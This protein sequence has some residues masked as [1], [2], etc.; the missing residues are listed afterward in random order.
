MRLKS[1]WSGGR[2][3][4]PSETIGGVWL[5]KLGRGIWCGINGERFFRKIEAWN[6]EK[7]EKN[8]SSSC[9]GVEELMKQCKPC[10]NPRG[11]SECGQYGFGMDT[12][13]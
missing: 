4:F 8:W 13:T 2:G 6:F 10:Q 9:R 5:R 12:V 11:Q 7:R 1:R 3:T